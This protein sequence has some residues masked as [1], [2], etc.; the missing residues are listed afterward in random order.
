MSVKISVSRLRVFSVS[1]HLLFKCNQ[2]LFNGIFGSPLNE[3]GE[4]VGL[5]GTIVLVHR[6]NVDL[7]CESHSR[8]RLRVV[9]AALDLQEV[10]PVIEVG[11]RGT[12]NGAVPVSESLVITYKQSKDG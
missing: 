10:D 3:H 5:N 8:R 11:V 2:N 1:N 7:R 6:R 4:L 12:N 9:L